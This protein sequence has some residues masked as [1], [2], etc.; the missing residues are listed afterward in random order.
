MKCATCKTVLTAQT[1]IAA[2]GHTP[3][4]VK[5]KAATCTEDGLTDGVRC[6]TCK[7][8]LTAQTKIAA[9]GHSYTSGVCSACGKDK[10][11]ESLEFALSEDGKSYYV[12]GIGSCTDTDVI[13]PA[14]YN[15]KPVTSIELEA[16]WGCDS[17]TSIT[18]PSS[19]TH[20]A[21]DA[22]LD[23]T[24]LAR[25]YISDLAVWCEIAFDDL[26]SSPFYYGAA[27]Y[28]NG[29]RITDLVIPNTVFYIKKNAFLGCSSITSIHI[30]ASVHVISSYAFYCCT[31][32]K[33]ITV[34]EKNI[35]YHSSGNCLIEV[36]KTL[37]LGCSTSVI[38]ND[39]SVETI[40]KLAFA[41]AP[42][43]T[44]IT[45]PD[46]VTEI[47]DSAFGACTALK[48]VTIG[49]N[50]KSIGE[51]AFV[52]CQSLT[53][54]TFD[55]TKAQWNAISKV[56]NWNQGSGKYTVHCTDGDVSK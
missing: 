44:T 12:T 32:L 42:S 15:G 52:A 40:G 37:I 9:K 3:E 46:S 7:A 11:N 4:T 56:N 26:I 24:S 31:S 39:G 27:L 2:K 55:G 41:N 29:E 1:K 16:F 51:Y 38:P 34:D 23:C 36:T 22:F 6:S 48:S 53:S 33:S 8:V 50:V 20:I 43:L 30:P 35:T 19:I 54:I 13:I 14:T 5:G 49:K 47:S 25:V 17:M 21:S 10:T 45:I 18:I 28:L